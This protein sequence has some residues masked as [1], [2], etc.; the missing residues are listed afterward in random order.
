M[1]HAWP[2]RPPLLLLLLLPTS[3]LF[4]ANRRPHVC[5][6]GWQEPARADECRQLVF[7]LTVR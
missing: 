1:R 3:I 2:R 5:P 4:N 7:K 6:A